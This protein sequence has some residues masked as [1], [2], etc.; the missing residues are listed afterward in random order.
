MIAS[1][2]HPASTSPGRIPA[3]NNLP[4]EVLVMAP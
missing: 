3:M 4:M 1:M 2:K